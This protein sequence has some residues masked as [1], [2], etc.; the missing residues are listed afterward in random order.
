MKEGIFIINTSRGGLVDE[1]AL[2]SG[3]KSGKIAGRDK[4]GR[5]SISYG[6]VCAVQKVDVLK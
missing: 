5:F 1:A 6:I 2:Y 4:E 3:L